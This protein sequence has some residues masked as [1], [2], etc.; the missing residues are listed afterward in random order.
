MFLLSLFDGQNRQP[1]KARA[2][3]STVGSADWFQESFRMV[4]KGGPSVFPIDLQTVLGDALRLSP[5]TVAS[6]DWSQEQLAI[7]AHNFS[8]NR[9]PNRTQ[10]QPD[11]RSANAVN[12]RRPFCTST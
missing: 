2:V 7:Q 1:K 10:R 8:H 12:S 5:S 9:S 3:P 4:Q 6:P 11:Q